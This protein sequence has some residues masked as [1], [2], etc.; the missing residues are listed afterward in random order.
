MIICNKVIL[1]KFLLNIFL[2]MKPSVNI[3]GLGSVA[4][5]AVCQS[6]FALVIVFPSELEMDHT[7]TYH[8]KYHLT[9]RERIYSLKGA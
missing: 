7:D 4:V 6:Q 2:S 3:R 1:R 9:W 5:S 8:W